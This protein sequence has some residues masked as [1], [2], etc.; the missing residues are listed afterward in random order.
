MIAL[1]PNYNFNDPLKL[2]VIF[3]EPVY[4]DGEDKDNYELY[5]ELGI[6]VDTKVD[7]EYTEHSGEVY[8]LWEQIMAIKSYPYQEDWKK[9]KGPK[10]YISCYDTTNDYLVF[11]DINKIVGY[12]TMYRNLTYGLA[13][14]KQ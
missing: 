7:R 10:F 6:K 9:F 1:D 8:I 2:T 14:D 13:E 4:K 11:G 3:R 12:W 5:Q